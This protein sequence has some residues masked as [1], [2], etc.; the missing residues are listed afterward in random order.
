MAAGERRQFY[1]MCGSGND[2]VFFDAREMPA[3]GLESGDAIY[4]D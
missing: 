2:F 1:K 4:A 3:G